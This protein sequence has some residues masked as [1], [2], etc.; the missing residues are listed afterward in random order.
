M[1]KG[2]VTAPFSCCQ[3]SSPEAIEPERGEDYRTPHGQ[4]GKVG[5][6]VPDQQV[7]QQPGRYVQFVHDGERAGVDTGAS[8]Y[9]PEHA[10][11]RGE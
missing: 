2:Q 3:A 6:A 8:L 9:P 1:K 10:E 11:G 4:A 7:D 5:F